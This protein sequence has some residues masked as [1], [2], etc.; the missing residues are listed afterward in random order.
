MGTS[1]KQ[2]T[3]DEVRSIREEYS[4]DPSI[5]FEYLA[6]KYERS[7]KYMGHIVRNETHYDPKYT[8]VSRKGGKKRKEYI[9]PHI[10]EMKDELSP[11]L[12]TAH[13]AR[14]QNYV[15]NKFS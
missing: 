1:R 6:A 12:N 4:N 10:Y 3:D 7:D 9:P 5:T 14:G 13:R 8:P 2:L 11:E 15:I